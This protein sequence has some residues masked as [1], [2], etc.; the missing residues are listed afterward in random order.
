MFLWMRSRYFLLFA[1]NFADWLSR[2]FLRLSNSDRLFS[3]QRTKKEFLVGKETATD[4]DLTVFL[5]R[6]SRD[7]RCYPVEARTFVDELYRRWSERNPMSTTPQT[8]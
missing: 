4:R 5:E 1:C 6:F 2:L 8:L 7:S 3:D